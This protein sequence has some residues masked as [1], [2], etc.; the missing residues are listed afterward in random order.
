MIDICSA[1]SLE[2]TSAVHCLAAVSCMDYQNWVITSTPVQL[3]NVK[4]LKML[5]AAV[6]DQSSQAG[7]FQHN[8]ERL[9]HHRAEQMHLHGLAG[10]TDSRQLM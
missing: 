1:L 10:L 5:C 6:A 9:S 2:K 4:P 3:Q 8:R 7:A